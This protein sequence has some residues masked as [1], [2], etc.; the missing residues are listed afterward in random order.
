MGSRGA[1]N[2]KGG[3]GPSETCQRPWG[4]SQKGEK[5]QAKGMHILTSETRTARPPLCAP[6]PPRHAL[7]PGVAT[8]PTLRMR[9][10][11][12]D[13]TFTSGDRAHLCVPSPAEARHSQGK[14]TLPLVRQIQ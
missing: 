6:P 11:C 9:S 8:T 7:L 3:S 1:C 13:N 12:P 14:A 10:R 4:G 2:G 5:G